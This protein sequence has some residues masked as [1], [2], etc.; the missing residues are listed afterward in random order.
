M[1][2]ECDL[3]VDCING[4]FGFENKWEEKVETHLKTCWECQEIVGLIGEV[5]NLVNPKIFSADMK[6]RI[7]AMVFEEPWPRSRTEPMRKSSPN[8][9][10][11]ISSFWKII[12]K[13]K[14]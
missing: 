2:T 6:A 10:F 3:M 9:P 7:L 13:S 8:W 12:K 4:S 11:F 14:S 1:E 5:P